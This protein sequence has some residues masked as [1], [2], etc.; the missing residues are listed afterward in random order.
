M[1]GTVRSFRPNFFMSYNSLLHLKIFDATGEVYE[2]QIIYGFIFEI[3][4]DFVRN[5]CM[6]QDVGQIIC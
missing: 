6:I 1:I 5:G 3:R 4:W 2:Y